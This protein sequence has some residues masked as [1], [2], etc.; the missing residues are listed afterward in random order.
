[1]TNKRMNS[2]INEDYN[3]LKLRKS[4]GLTQSD[5]G[6]L[7]KVS[8]NY[9]CQIE[10]GRKIP[11][12]TLVALAQRIEGELA[13]AATSNDPSGSGGQSSRGEAFRYLEKIWGATGEDRDVQGYVLTKL[14]LAFPLDRPPFVFSS[15]D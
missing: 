14:K 4:F 1:M 13:E 10:T 15:E 5:L 12:E 2:S 7:L 9:I 3:F 11:S 8:K 6:D